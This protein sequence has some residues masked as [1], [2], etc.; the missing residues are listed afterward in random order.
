MTVFHVP[1]EAGDRRRYIPAQ[2]LVADILHPCLL[3]CRSD[4]KQR[5]KGERLFDCRQAPE[6]V[7]EHCRANMNKVIEKVLTE[8]RAAGFMGDDFASTLMNHFLSF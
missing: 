5:K 8:L 4:R 3:S 7:T 2:L 6:A 1:E